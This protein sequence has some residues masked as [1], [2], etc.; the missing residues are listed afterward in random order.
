M[1][2]FVVEDRTINRIVSHLCF[3][4]DLEWLRSE[5]CEAARAA[6]DEEIGAALFKLNCDAVEARYGVGEA[7]KFRPLDYQ[8]QLESASARQ[9]YDEIA[10]LQY[11][12]SEGDVPETALFKLLVQ[13]RAAVA[14]DV[15]GQTAQQGEMEAELENSL[16][17]RCEACCK[18][19]KHDDR[20]CGAPVAR[21]LL[22]GVGRIRRVA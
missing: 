8:F 7:A 20:H 9:V 6:S 1:S 13:L 12:C 15:I 3:N 11:Q 5:F 10:T 22:V 16:Y 19:I 21:R 2:A 4:R 17:A 14:D 18:G